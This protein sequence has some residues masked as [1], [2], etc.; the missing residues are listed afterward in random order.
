M[1]AWTVLLCGG[2]WG[3]GTLLMFSNPAHSPGRF[4]VGLLLVVAVGVVVLAS[5]LQ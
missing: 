2:L 4:V 3:I 5:G 1:K